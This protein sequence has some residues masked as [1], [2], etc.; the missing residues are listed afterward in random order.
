MKN[1]FVYTRKEVVK[2]TKEG[3]E[4]KLVSYTDSFNMSKVIR[5]VQI[6]PD[7]LLILLDDL[8]ERMEKVPQFDHKKTKVTGYTKERNM[9]QSEIYLTEAS[10]IQRFRDL[11]TIG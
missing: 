11:T 7:E 1:Q 4:D 2:A 5:S 8:H 9:F 3:E 6:K 10:D